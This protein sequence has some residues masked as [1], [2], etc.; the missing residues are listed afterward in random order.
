[1]ELFHEAGVFAYV[2]AV[3][4]VTT[5]VFAV[6]RPDRA[7]ARASVGACVIFAVGMVGSA[8][9]QRLVDRALPEVPSV[10]QKVTILSAGTRET[11]ANLLLAGMFS[12]ALLGVAGGVSA[13]R[14]RG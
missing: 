10:E 6:K 4:F 1:M 7:L 9:G 14:D 5:L 3:A 13:A 12:L 2:S 11:S 8:L